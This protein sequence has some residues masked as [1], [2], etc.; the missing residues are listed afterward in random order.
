[1]KRDYRQIV[2][3]WY[4]FATPIFILLDYLWGINVRVSVLDSMPLYKNLYYGFCIT[5]A[6]GICIFP[7]YSAVVA[8]AESTINFLMVVFF[9][10]TP[11]VY[12]LTHMD[13][14]LSAVSDVENVFSMQRI[15]NLFLAGLVAVFAF[16][17]SVWKLE[18]PPGP[19]EPAS[20]DSPDSD[21]D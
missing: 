13:D 9:L 6:V 21:A 18:A 17:S 8:L 15:A 20:G 1:M 10:F 14:V 4:Y 12:C 11:Y 19:I 3:R 16:R 7:R 2:A 5:C